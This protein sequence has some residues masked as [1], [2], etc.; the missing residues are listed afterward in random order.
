MKLIPLR[1]HVIQPHESLWEIVDQYVE[2]LH[3]YSV[4]ALSAKIVSMCQGRLVSKTEGLSKQD[5]VQQEA[6]FYL[7]P[8]TSRY[9]LCLTIKHGVLIPCAGID[10]SNAQD[11]Y[12]LYPRDIQGTV[13]AIWRYL[14]RRDSVQALGVI[15]TDSRT[16]PLR[17]GT[18]GVALGWCGFRPLHSYVGDQDC[19]GRMLHVSVAN[20]IDALAAAAVLMMGEGAEQTPLVRLEQATFLHYQDEPPSEEDLASISI[21]MDEDLYAPLL[22]GAPWV[23]SDGL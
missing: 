12:I 18:T 10:E 1:T 11:H 7:P 15:M 4:L 20:H 21:P 8:D 6:D 17:R 14:R 23:R 9:G 13:E 22:Q 3:E 2:P 5:L 16:T 19:F